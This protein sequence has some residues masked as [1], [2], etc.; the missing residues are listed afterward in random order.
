MKLLKHSESYNPYGLKREYGTPLTIEETKAYFR[1]IR[2]TKEELADLN[3]WIKDGNRFNQNPW[4]IFSDKG[5]LVNFIE[6]SRCVKEQIES[7]T[8]QLLVSSTAITECA[9]I[10][11]AHPL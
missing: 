8:D 1:A 3:E 4:L 2:I 7:Y 11:L 9:F 6:A 10:Y 5:K